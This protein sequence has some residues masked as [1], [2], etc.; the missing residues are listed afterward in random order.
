MRTTLG[1]STSQRAL[2]L[3]GLLACAASIAFAQS[4]PIPRI[5]KKGDKF[6]F[7]VDGKPFIMLGAKSDGRSFRTGS[8][9]AGQV[10]EVLI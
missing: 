7:T 10:N 2:G 4:K 8:P 3:C 5:A 6:T 1:R 9:D